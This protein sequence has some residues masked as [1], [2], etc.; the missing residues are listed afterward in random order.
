MHRTYS[1]R[2]SRAPTASQVEVGQKPCP[3]RQTQTRALGTGSAETLTRVPGCRI[4]RRRRRPQSIGSSVAAVS[5]SDFPVATRD[6]LSAT[7]MPTRPAL[8]HRTPLI[9]SNF[10]SL[11]LW[12]HRTCD[13]GQDGGRL[14]ARLVQEAYAAGQDGEEPHAQPRAVR[15]GAHGS[16]GMLLPVLQVQD[17]EG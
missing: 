6:K 3:T 16:S 8:H 17:P 9:R 2:K 14:R 5:V 4:P 15:Q 10:W 11:I 1:M 12:G 7:N 13:S